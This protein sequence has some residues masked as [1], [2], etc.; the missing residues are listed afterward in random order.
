MPL[1]N[2]A[3]REPLSNE[4]RQDVATAITT[5]HC[6]ETGAPAEFVNVIFLDNYPLPAPQDVS[7]LGGV[8]IGGT[9][10][11]E[12]IDRLRAALLSDIAETIGRPATAVG[13]TLVG[14]PSHWIVEGGEVMPAPGEEAE[15]LARKHG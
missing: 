10:T 9:R 1:Y 8:R 6:R 2:V 15:W 3:C 4:K 11:P 7:L 5:A 12:V 14:V 13:M